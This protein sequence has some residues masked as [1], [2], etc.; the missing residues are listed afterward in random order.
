MAFFDA[1]IAMRFFCEGGIREWKHC[2][3]GLSVADFFI[4]DFN[5]S[6]PGRAVKASDKKFASDR[7]RRMPSIAVPWQKTRSSKAH[8]AWCPMILKLNLQLTDVH[9]FNNL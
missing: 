8:P 7:G 9:Y 3:D 6:D 1:R 2:F 5:A 4:D